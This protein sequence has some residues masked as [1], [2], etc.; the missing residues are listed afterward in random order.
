MCMKV[1]ENLVEKIGSCKLCLKCQGKKKNNRKETHGKKWKKRKVKRKKNTKQ[2]MCM[3][4]E[5]NR[6]IGENE[7]KMGQK[8]DICPYIFLNMLY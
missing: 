8:D 6:S 4:W 2:I 3:M 1:W 7:G 5:K